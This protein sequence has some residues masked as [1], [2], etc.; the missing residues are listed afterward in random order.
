MSGLA[1]LS[2]LWSVAAAQTITVQSDP[3]VLKGKRSLTASPISI[4]EPRLT[5]GVTA[6]VTDSV[7]RVKGL[8]TGSGSIRGG[9]VNKTP[10]TLREGNEF[11]FTSLLNG[12]LNQLHITLR[13]SD[14]GTYTRTIDVIY[15][16]K[17]P[18]IEVL[19]PRHEDVRG[20][21][22]MEPDSGRLRA[23]VYDESGIRNATIDGVP[24]LVKPDSTVSKQFV[25]FRGESTSL[26]VATHNAG[27]SREKRVR[28]EYGRLALEFMDWKRH[29]LIIGIDEYRGAWPP[30][31]NAVRDA[32]EV[33]VLLRQQFKFASIRTLYNTEATRSN[34]LSTMEGL[35]EQLGPDDNLLI[36]YSGHGDRKE[37][38]KAGYWVPVDADKQMSAQYVAN[39]EI[40]SM[41]GGMKARHVLVVADACFAG[42]LVRGGVQPQPL[43]KNPSFYENESG[44]LSRKALTSGAKE[45][46]LDGGR[47]GHSIFAYYF[48][49]AL[50]EIEGDYFDVS[51]VFARV[52]TGVGMNARQMPMYNALY[53]TGD[54]GG[55]FIFVRK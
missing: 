20:I 36:Y 47:D 22:L 1:L 37:Q 8:F 49:Q 52:R 33:E 55:E 34:I 29:A 30:L 4:L 18:T 3:F 38:F 43:N 16:T 39:T 45:P 15:D 10:L 2:L 25:R 13:N 19:E 23:K 35:A 44:R 27:R 14:A 40:I 42:E 28:M 6:V 21:R 31:Q 24:V 11:A 5:E 32:K 26:I 50:R 51:D 53:D 54:N 41:I 9:T 12:G 17:P 46:V 48:L 7:F